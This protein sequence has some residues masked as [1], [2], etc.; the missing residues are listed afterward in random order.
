MMIPSRRQFLSILGGTAAAAALGSRNALAVPK[1]ESFE[2]LFITDTHLQP[3]LQASQGCDMA[4]KKARTIKA[5]FAIQGGDHVFDTMQVPKERAVSLFDLYGKTEQDLGLKVYHIC[6]NHDCFGISSNG[7]TPLGDQLYGKKMFE[8][9]FGR[10]YSSF[11]HKGVHFVVLDSVQPEPDQ[12]G[13]KRGT[14]TKPSWRGWRTISLSWRLER[15]SL[16]P[17]TSP[18]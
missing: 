8:E 6:G 9:R 5:D 4:F 15:R 1:S 16:S 7:S 11:D 12:T 2:F 13:Y 17:P 14:L 10:A 3:E 18:W